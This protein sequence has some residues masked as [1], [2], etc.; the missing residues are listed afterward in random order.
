VSLKIGV[1]KGEKMLSK[2]SSDFDPELNDGKKD[3]Q[4]LWDKSESNFSE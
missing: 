3:S 2:H 4:K 1:I